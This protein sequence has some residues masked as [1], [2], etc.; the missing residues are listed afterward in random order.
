MYHEDGQQKAHLVG[1][2]GCLGLCFLHN[3]SHS[4]APDGVAEWLSDVRLI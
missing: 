3:E 4:I 2:A 1:W